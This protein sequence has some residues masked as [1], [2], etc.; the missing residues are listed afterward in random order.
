MSPIRLRSDRPF[1]QHGLE[2]LLGFEKT[3]GF[4]VFGSQHR[5]PILLYQNPKCDPSFSTLESLRLALKV[6][7]PTFRKL[8]VSG[9]Q[10]PFYLFTVSLD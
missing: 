9:L 4:Q 5:L 3:G 2:A 1:S 7:Q 10:G 8:T 6:P